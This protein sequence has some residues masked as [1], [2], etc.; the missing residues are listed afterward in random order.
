MM[1]LISFIASADEISINVSTALT[2]PSSPLCTL[3]NI[4]IITRYLRIAGLS[5]KQLTSELN[6]TVRIPLLIH[7]S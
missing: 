4:Y 7:P 6:F 1:R 3:I 2:T 5:L